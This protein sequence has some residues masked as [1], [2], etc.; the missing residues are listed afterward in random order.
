MSCHTT[1]NESTKVQ[2]LGATMSRQC[3]KHYNLITVSLS[4]GQQQY[5]NAV[6]NTSSR[7]LLVVG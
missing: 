3:C 7:V 2:T 1:K 6:L 4:E 5:A